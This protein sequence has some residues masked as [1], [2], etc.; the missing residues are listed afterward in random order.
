MDGSLHLAVGVYG[1]GQNMYNHRDKIH[2]MMHSRK[3][4]LPTETKVESGTSQ[5]KVEPLLT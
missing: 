4:A 3:G 1:L 2:Q 5:N